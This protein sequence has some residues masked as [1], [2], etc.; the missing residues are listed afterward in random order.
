MS[1]GFQV[2]LW[3][4]AKMATFLNSL[5]VLM[6]FASGTQ[7]D[8]KTY[9]VPPEQ[10][11]AKIEVVFLDQGLV[12]E[13]HIIYDR[14]LRLARYEYSLD[15]KMAPYYTRNPMRTV[16]DYNTGKK[17]I[18]CMEST[19]LQGTMFSSSYNM[20]AINIAYHKNQCLCKVVLLVRPLNCL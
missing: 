3:T 1:Y 16:C 19:P 4:V 7:I 5:M 14:S 18:K 9:L 10:F 17:F 20:F 12:E 13:F 11:S 2:S 15:E 6:N 8:G